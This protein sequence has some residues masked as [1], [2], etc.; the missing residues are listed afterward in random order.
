MQQA[1]FVW[2]VNPRVTFVAMEEL[3]SV[4]MK[5]GPLFAMNI[6]MMLMQVWY[7]TNLDTQDMVCYQIT[8]CNLL[9]HYC[10]TVQ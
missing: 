1:R 5:H 7:A 3:K 6:G 4:S 10:V 2:L 8:G 9:I